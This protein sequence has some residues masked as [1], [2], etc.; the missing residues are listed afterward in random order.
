MKPHSANDSLSVAVVFDSNPI[1]NTTSTEI[2]REECGHF[3]RTS[4]PTHISI[5]WYLPDVV[6]Q[7]RLFQM[8]EH[9]LELLP[10]IAKLETILGRPLDASADTLRSGVERL[11]AETI[12]SLGIIELPLDPARVDWAKVVAM[13]TRRLPPF[14]RGK[15]EKG[16]RDALIAESFF[17]LHIDAQSLHDLFVLVTQDALLKTAVE[18]NLTQDLRIVQDISALATLVNTLESQLDEKFIKGLVPIAG[19]LFFKPKQRDS[20][21]YRGKVKNLIEQQCATELQAVPSNG[22]TRCNGTWRIARPTFLRK[23]DNEIVWSTKI[24]IVATATVRQRRYVPLSELRMKGPAASEYRARPTATSVTLLS[25]TPEAS[26]PD[27]EPMDLEITTHKGVDVYDVT[28]A[29]R[30]DGGTLKEPRIVSI[31][32]DGATWE[33]LIDQGVIDYLTPLP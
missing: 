17:Q 15:K 33:S 26:Q 10:S 29:T 1:F 12:K 7:E 28:W 21:Y 8:Q 20:L 22:L 24:S 27:L 3:I 31:V 25:G 13:S 6:R 2:I 16:F 18:S 11:V 5:S 23:E 32:H 30:I 19:G 14:E 4:K 9:A